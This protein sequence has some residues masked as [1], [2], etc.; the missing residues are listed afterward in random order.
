MYSP[1]IF[2]MYYGNFCHFLKKI[3]Q[4]FFL[5]KRTT[6]TLNTRDGVVGET[7]WFPY[8]NGSVIG[9]NPMLAN[10]IVK[11]LLLNN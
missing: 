9:V 5:K 3:L 6:K 8:K 4:K 1:G 2:K 10:P 7:S 11:S